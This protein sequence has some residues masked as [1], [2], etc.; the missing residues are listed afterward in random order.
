MTHT[1]QGA[2]STKPKPTTEDE[3]PDITNQLPTAKVKDLYVYTD[4]IS[5]LYTDDMGR[6]PVCSC[7]GNHYIMLAY[8]I[9]NNTILVESFQSC[10]DRHCIASY[11]CIMMRLKKRGHTVDL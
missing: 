10:Q 9:D 7:S 3:P 5:K 6:F 4:P 11:N 1:R 2:C 8:H